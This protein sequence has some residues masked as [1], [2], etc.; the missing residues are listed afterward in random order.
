MKI[1]SWNLNSLTI[2]LPILLE[3]IN[4][5]HPDFIL[6]QETKTQDINFPTS[7][8]EEHGYT[9]YFYGQKTFNGVAILVKNSIQIESTTHILYEDKNAR[10]LEVRCE[11]FDR[12]ISIISIYIPNGQ[13]VESEKFAYKL[14]FLD[15]LY[16]KLTEI[17]KTHEIIIGGDFNIACEEIDLHNPKK[18]QNKCSF[19]IQERKMIQKIKNLDL[20][21]VWRIQNP[22]KQEFSWWDYRHGSFQKNLG[23]R[24]DYYLLSAFLA[25]KIQKTEILNKVR[26]MEKTSD[27]APLLMELRI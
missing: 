14:E 13:D 12:K 4:T 25:Q 3:L 6:L 11:F 1:L 21:D 9:S 7:Q 20:F 26:K 27:H 15:K 24:I 5:H 8:I 18:M 2:R 16:E 22:E 10:F 17:Q 23:M 19:T